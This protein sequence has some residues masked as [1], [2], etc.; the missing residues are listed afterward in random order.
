V[1]LYLVPGN[2]NQSCCM[3]RNKQLNTWHMASNCRWLH[4]SLPSPL[5]Q[6]T[7]FFSYAVPPFSFQH[8]WIPVQNVAWTQKFNLTPKGGKKTCLESDKFWVRVPLVHL[9]RDKYNYLYKY[10]LNLKIFSALNSALRLFLAF[11]KVFTF[12][13]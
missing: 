6:T 9:E 1:L 12:S 5:S 13:N 2:L 3:F 8:N 10:Y 7:R 4:V 11:K